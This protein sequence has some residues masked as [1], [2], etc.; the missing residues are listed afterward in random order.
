MMEFVRKLKG[1]IGFL[2]QMAPYFGGSGIL[3][4]YAARDWNRLM[5]HLNLRWQVSRVRIPI[6][7]YCRSAAVRPDSSDIRVLEQ[8][9]VLEQYLPSARIQDPS[10][11]VDCGANAGY[12]SIFFLE[13]FPSARV[14]ALEPDPRNAN[15]CRENLRKY[16]DRV[17]VL[18]KALWG[19]V[20]KLNFVE[21]SRAQGAEWGV[22]VRAGNGSAGSRTV[23]A[24]DIPS[25]M[26]TTDIEFIDL[27]KIDIEKSETE[28]FRMNP[29]RWLQSVGN[30]A[31]ELHGPECTE[32]FHTALRDFSFK[33]E[34]CGEVTFCFG[35]HPAG[36][37]SA[38]G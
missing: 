4:W 19:A 18:E 35:M 26:A 8:V 1:R 38:S 37:D 16:K 33:E 30:I 23:E 22:E 5:R 34:E 28:V 27:L 25:L 24:L 6:K 11:I 2:R 36:S 7:G 20:A 21:E 31:I 29:S 14:I 10:I 12:S 15:I 13:R 9:F 3:A 17:V 32:V